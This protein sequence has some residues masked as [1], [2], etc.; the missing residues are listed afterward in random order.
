[1][2]A[3]YNIWKNIFFRLILQKGRPGWANPQLAVFQHFMRSLIFS[4]FC[5]RHELPWLFH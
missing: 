3:G 4:F 2:I 5:H 1:M